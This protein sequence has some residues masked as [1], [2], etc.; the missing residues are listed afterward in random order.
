MT[1]NPPSFPI[2]LRKNKLLVTAS[3]ALC[4]L[5]L[6][7]F[8]QL[9]LTSLLTLLLLLRR[10]NSFLLYDLMFSLPH[11]CTQISALKKPPQRGLSFSIKWPSR[12]MLF[13]C[14]FPYS[15]SVPSTGTYAL[16]GQNPESPVQNNS[17]HTAGVPQI[18][19]KQTR[20]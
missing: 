7:I 19:A 17:W 3:K 15:S 9:H 13:W 2:A 18:S 10:A 5:A 16:G 20:L 14:Y 12:S 6:P 8:L 1:Q 4:H 11:I